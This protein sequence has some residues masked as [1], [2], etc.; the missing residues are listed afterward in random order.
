MK[1][2]GDSPRQARRRQALI[3]VALLMIPIV[4]FAL[5]NREPRHNGMPAS[6]YVRAVLTNNHFSVSL[7]VR[8]FDPLGTDVTVAALTKVLEQEDAGWKHW[9][10]KTLPRTPLWL[11]KHLKPVRFDQN[12]I[13]ACAG[14]LG[15]FG[16]EAEPAVPALIH[17]FNHGNDYVRRQIVSQLSR[18]GPG[19]RD[20]IP[21]LLDTALKQ[22]GNPVN[23]GTRSAAIRALANIDPGGTNSAQKLVALCADST[24]PIALAA[25]EALGIMASHTPSLITT[26]RDTLRRNK[27]GVCVSAARHLKRLNALTRDDIEPFLRLLQDDNG[28]N[29]A[30]GASVLGFAQAY[31]SDVVPLLSQ[32]A[33]DTNEVVREAATKSLIGFFKDSN[34]QVSNQTAALKAVLQFGSPDDT[35]STLTNIS[36]VTSGAIDIVPLLIAAL[37]NDNE[38]VRGRAAQALGEIDSASTIAL[39]ALQRI[40]ADDW[41]NVREAATNAIRAIESRIR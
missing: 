17:S 2:N 12:L 20:A 28:A 26:L 15:S 6:E 4:W 11:R 16:P 31:D 14:A 27:S 21:I 24:L 36:K 3:V 10:I 29:R 13:I 41:R 33:A 40:R 9:Y 30:F 1:A 8:H 34:V 35:Y 7:S 18:I 22:G 32:V 19:A 39:P 25:T 37:D 23:T 38:R 5:V